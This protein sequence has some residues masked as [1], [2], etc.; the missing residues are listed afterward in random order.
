MRDAQALL[1]GLI[2]PFAF[3]PFS[4]WPLAIVSIFGLFHAW[5]SASP[6]RSLLR[7][8]LFGLG[9]FGVGLSWIYIS[10][11]QFSPVSLSIAIFLNFL[12]IAFLALFPAVTGYVATWVI[13]KRD[14]VAAGLL[15]A[16]LWVFVEWSRSWMFTGFPWLS[17]GY[18]QI[19][20]PLA[21][22]APLLGVTGVSLMV[23]LSAGLILVAFQAKRSVAVIA[24]VCVVLVIGGGIVLRDRSWTIA[25]EKPLRVVLLQGNV[26][27]KLKWKPDHRKRILEL[28]AGLTELYLGYDLIVWPETAAPAFEDTLPEYLD[29]LRKKAV[30]Y[31]SDLVLGI[32]VRETQRKRYYNALISVGAN[33]DVYYKRHLV[34]FGEYVPLPTL[35]T[36]VLKMFGIRQVDFSSGEAELPILQLSG[37]KAG[38]SICYEVVFGSELREALP[39]AEL[40]INVSNDA[41]FGDSLA[42]HQHFEMARMR[43]LESGR[44]ML[45]STNTGIS[46]IIDPSGA[47]IARSP[48]FRTHALEARVFRMNGATP[49]VVWG[50]LPVLSIVLV[51]MAFSLWARTR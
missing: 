33:N 23:T 26:D 16:V 15:M 9:Q 30:Q 41:W 19:D 18:S 4:F 3:A 24:A 27:Q 10:I 20:G 13:S 8:W 2:L 44:Y 40:L 31:G 25:N 39:A 12:I 5:S 43:A 48:Q 1:A 45:R 47:V 28:Y 35:L 42:P 36:P 7:G 32:P 29:R 37:Y 21:G 46:G 14:G 38:V 6:L 22:Y 11:A 49:Y 50:E 34:P 17:L 51:V